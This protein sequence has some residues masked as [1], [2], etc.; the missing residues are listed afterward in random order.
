MRGIKPDDYR[1]LAERDVELVRAEAAHLFIM[2]ENG[3]S[4]R[5]HS[6]P[7]LGIIAVI[8]EPKTEPLHPDLINSGIKNAV[9]LEIGIGKSRPY[10]ETSLPQSRRN[11]NTGRNWLVKRRKWFSLSPDQYA[12]IAPELFKLME[13][14][15]DRKVAGRKCHPGNPFVLN[16]PTRHYSQNNKRYSERIKTGFFP[17]GTRYSVNLSD[18]LMLNDL[19]WATLYGNL[20]VIR[21]ISGAANFINRC[22]N[23]YKQNGYDSEKF[24]RLKGIEYIR[25]SLNSSLFSD[26]LKREVLYYLPGGN[27]YRF[28]ENLAHYFEL[29]LEDYPEKK[30]ALKAN[31]TRPKTRL[32]Q[33]QL[34][35]LRE[36]SD[37]AVIEVSV[38]EGHRKFL[39]EQNTNTALLPDTS[40]DAVPF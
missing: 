18:E 25:N 29:D 26:W 30:R 39:P 2:N 22:L 5:K 16:Y 31:Q 11:G 10:H 7:G 9:L 6:D 20:Q 37:H 33:I 17:Q 3:F 23:R 27:S 8:G 24:E 19:Y 12:A 35:V 4:Y 15:T 14:L 21:H 34:R 13:N 32:G 28:F 40:N 1:L 38:G 36:V